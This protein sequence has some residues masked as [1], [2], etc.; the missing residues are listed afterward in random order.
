MLYH[1]RLTVKRQRLGE[2]VAVNALPP[3]APEGPLGEAEEKA[4]N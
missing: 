4:E 3:P 2:A 1:L